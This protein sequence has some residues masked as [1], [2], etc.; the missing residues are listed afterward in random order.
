M[1]PHSRRQ[2]AGLWGGVNALPKLIS[3]SP[4]ALLRFFAPLIIAVVNQRDEHFQQFK[5]MLDLFAKYPDIHT[6]QESVCPTFFLAY[7]VSKRRR[8][9]VVSL[10][11]SKEAGDP[12]SIAGI[13]WEVRA[14]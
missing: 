1:P 9:W 2:A 8:I 12:A 13:Q 11:L 6:C 14:E 5:D 7:G 10:E 3:S 4:P